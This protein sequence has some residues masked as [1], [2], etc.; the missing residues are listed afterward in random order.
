MCSPP[1]DLQPARSPRLRP[2]RSSPGCLRGGPRRWRGGSLATGG[3]PLARDGEGAASSSSARRSSP[4]TQGAG[5]SGGQRRSL[6]IGH[7]GP[8]PVAVPQILQHDTRRGWSLLGDAG[9]GG[10]GARVV[11]YVR[12]MLRDGKIFPLRHRSSPCWS[13]A[14][15]HSSL[16]LKKKQF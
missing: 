7:V 14:T 12:A 15:A 3:R 13:P 16:D 11:L 2:T 8:N 10:A 6:R 9:D 5:G 1:P 4:S